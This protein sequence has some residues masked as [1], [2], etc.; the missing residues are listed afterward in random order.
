MA[1]RTRKALI[2]IVLLGWLAAA[3]AQQTQIPSTNTPQPATG[4]TEMPTQRPGPTSTNA[5]TAQPSPTPSGIWITLAPDS[6]KPGDTIQIKGYLPGGPTQQSAQK[7]QSMSQVTVCWKGCLTGL[8]EEGQ[9]IEWSD[10]EAGHF[11][12]QFWVPSQPWLSSK[13]PE[14]LQPGDY[15]VGVQC[16]GGQAGCALEQAQASTTFHLEGPTPKTCQTGQPCAHLTFTPDQAPPGTDIQVHGWAPLV[17]TIG[18]EEALGYNLVLVQ[19]STN[20]APV[21]LGQTKQGMDGTITGSFVVP[22]QGPSLGTLTPGSYQLALSAIRP[23]AYPNNRPPLVAE[24]SFEIT[25]PPTWS[26]LD[27]GQPVWVEPSANLVGKSLTVVPSKAGVLAY[28][29]PGEIGETQDGG[30]TWSKIPTT[31]VAAVA[32]AGGYPLMAQNTGGQ[33][34]CDSV[35]LDSAH[36]DSYFAVF[37]AA[38]KQYGAPPVFFMGYFTTDGGQTWKMVP[39]PQ[40][41]TQE[42]FGG[43]WSD[44][45]GMVQALFSGEPGNPAAASPVVVEQ[46][47]DG[48]A[49]WS[50]GNLTCAASGAC[51]RWGPAPGSI[52]GMGSPLPQYIMASTDGGK[53]WIQGPSVELRTIGPKELAAFSGQEALVIDGSADF[54]VQMTEDGGKTWQVVG[55][56]AMPGASEGAQQFSGLQILPDGA[57]VVL[58]PDGSS[59]MRLDSK[60]DQWCPV[61]GTD[62]PNYAALIQASGD[63]LWWLPAEAQAPEHTAISNMSC[64][65]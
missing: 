7:D 39:A 58:S 56:P 1:M 40:E 10:S 11:T 50:P 59:W 25:A 62:L 34:A 17:A 20:E 35:T 61:S 21:N 28:C 47:S 41:S 31:Q 2:C 29:G 38:N 32:E 3:C 37:Q 4:A 42:M 64:G 44:G 27:L 51:L 8:T 18:N 52:P 60:S 53:T 15:S 43:F 19:A 9:A 49:S 54:P 12:T 26:Q 63:Q 55:L 48:G 24:T 36:P 23:Q 16:L 46:T 45:N 6:G 22:Q 65:R 5:V 30:R 14:P 13:G 57:L 33:P